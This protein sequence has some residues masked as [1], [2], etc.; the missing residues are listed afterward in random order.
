MSRDSLMYSTFILTLVC[1]IAASL[2]GLAYNATAAQIEFQQNAYLHQNLNQIFPE[3][4][5]FLHEEDYYIAV[6]NNEKIGFVT[7]VVS[8][9]YSSFLTILVGMDL[10]KNIAGMRVLEHAETPGLGAE[11]VKPKFYQQFSNKKE[12]SKDT[13]DAITSATIT[14]DSVIKGVNEISKKLESLVENE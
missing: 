4:D 11:A 12:I 6:K 3:A 10:D 13:I 9:G 1:L 8:P 2:L 7:T 5:D 14:T